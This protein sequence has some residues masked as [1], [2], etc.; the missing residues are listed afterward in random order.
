MLLFK[1]DD[2]QKHKSR[3]DKDG[4]RHTAPE[5]DDTGDFVRW[6]CCGSTDRSIVGCLAEGSVL[7]NKPRGFSSGFQELNES[8]PRLLSAKF[9]V[10]DADDDEATF[11]I[12]DRGVHSNYREK[13]EDGGIHVRWKGYECWANNHE[14]PSNRW[15]HLK[16]TFDCR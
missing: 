6:L 3:V 12:Y 10:E 11:S 16:V 4:V 14:V 7:A 1:A 15:V 8:T 13:G 5:L 9:H 2:T